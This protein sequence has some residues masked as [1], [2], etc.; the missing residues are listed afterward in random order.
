MGALELLPVERHSGHL[1]PLGH[2]PLLA[3]L[4]H[5]QHV[6][7]LDDVEG[8]R[9]GLDLA[10]QGRAEVRPVLVIAPLHIIA[11]YQAR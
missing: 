9:V 2:G 7:A 3:F 8:V 5:H 6:A 10:R 1:Q 11:P 4:A